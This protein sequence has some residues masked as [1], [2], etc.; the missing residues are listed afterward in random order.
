M[1][2]EEE[3]AVE[4]RAA[5]ERAP[6]ETDL[7]AGVALRRRRRTR[8]RVRT[9]AAALAVVV[10][11]VGVRSVVLSGGGAGDVASTPTPAPPVP[12][13][14]PVERLWPGALSTLPVSGPDGA[15]YQ[16]ITAVSPTEI[17]FAA[18]EPGKKGAGRLEVFDTA[19][20]RIRLVTEVPGARR[21]MMPSASAD[22]ENVIWLHSGRSLREIWTAPLGGGAGRL[23]TTLRG[24][25][26][27]IDRITVNDGWAI[28]S[29]RRG[30]VWRVPLTGGTPARVPAG[31]GLHLLRWPWA[32]DVPPV[33]ESDERDQRVLVD[34]SSGA[35]TGIVARPGT[36]RLRCGPRW[37][38][39]HDARG[40]FVQRIDGSR[41]RRIGGDPNR[42][43]GAP[44][45]DRFVPF[46]SGVYDVETGT[47]A[48]I[49]DDRQVVH[50][51]SGEAGSVV[52]WVVGGTYRMLNLAAVPSAQ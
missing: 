2:T 30:G 37:C 52:Y 47:M 45:L 24:A 51:L 38:L 11:G 18:L 1:R 5:G 19:A 21:I 23:V 26:T 36:T 31:D 29:E 43:V 46:E 28:W 20:G 7:L 12:R 16:P 44:V 48:T 39:G 3:L 42:P 10:L 40:T 4:L 34:L 27:D 49:E 17:L 13:P 22:G 9:L 25:R 50:G 33:R 14:V 15:R 32:G 8:R 41:Q 35:S 6:G